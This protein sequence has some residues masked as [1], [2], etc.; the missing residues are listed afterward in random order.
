LNLLEDPKECVI[1]IDSEQFSFSKTQLIFIS[2]KALN[3]FA[4]STDPFI[5]DTSNMANVSIIDLISA[6]KS[7]ISLLTTETELA[8]DDD[9][10][11]SL[12]FLAES[13]GNPCLL[14]Q[15][16]NFIP[17]KSQIFKLSSNALTHLR[18]NEGKDFNNCHLT[19]NENIFEINSSLFCCISDKQNEF[20]EKNSQPF[21]SVFSNPEEH[22]KCFSAFLNI[23]RGDPF[24]HQEYAL[25][26]KLLLIHTFGLSPL[27]QI[28]S[29]S[30]T[31]PQ[32]IQEAIQFLKINHCEIFENHFNQCTALLISHL[33]EI[34][35]DDF[36]SL[37]N[38]VLEKLF[39]A[40][41]LQ[42]VNE[43]FLLELICK[44]SESDPNR[45]SLLKTVKFKYVS[46]TLLQSKLE[47]FSLKDFDVETFESLKER[48][49]S[50]LLHKTLI[51]SNS[52]WKNPPLFHSE[53]EIRQLKDTIS[54]KDQEI[55]QMNDSIKQ[56]DQMITYFQFLSKYIKPIC[57][58]GHNGI[59]FA[60]NSQKSGSVT[61]TD[62][63]R[64]CESP[65]HLLI[66]NNE[67]LCLS[68]KGS[69][70]FHF[71]DK[72]IYVSK[73]L[74]RS[75]NTYYP[76]SWRVEGSNDQ[77]NWEF[78]D[79]QT[80]EKSLETNFTEKVFN[81]EAN[82]TRLTSEGFFSKAF[83]TIKFT[84]EDDQS[85]WSITYVDFEGIVFG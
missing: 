63:N 52:R 51:C 72:K 75:W 68:R 42:I 69:V 9:N 67:R 71:A 83:S 62:E 30:L 20:P 17:S 45:K 56:K 28:I 78:I 66:Y 60:L 58:I 53:E 47:T 33:E 57:F 19:I 48:L 85:D 49:F 29:S 73:Y 70:S 25:P 35:I 14:E 46:S 3:H 7:L 65:E 40:P 31:A 38:F 84:P 8:I 24:Q 4:E 26:S 59:M 5:F 12:T 82:S 21:E 44:L 37:S 1:Q 77:K 10:I 64:C 11:S 39:S 41:N 27:A 74:I 6:F 18:E 13:L 80:N 2:L 81:C 32:T 55:K 50:E 16:S 79:R 61:I 22:F 76:H 34:S 36:R 43:D 23:F 15:C 54:R